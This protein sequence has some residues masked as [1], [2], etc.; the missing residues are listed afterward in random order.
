MFDQILESF[1]KA[2]ESS[3]QM[4]QDMVRQWTQQWLSLSPNTATASTE[5]GR[6]YQKRWLGFMLELL[7]KHRESLNTT[8]KSGIQVVEQAFRVSEARSSDE[9]RKTVED[10]WRKLFDTFKE[11]SEGQFSEFQRF[12]ERSFEMVQGEVAAQQRATA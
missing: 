2:S 8:Y 12:A 10:L 6:A 5:W 9:Y 4:Q 7:D 11:N 1:R 3:L